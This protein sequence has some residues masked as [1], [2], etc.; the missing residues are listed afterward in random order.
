MAAMPEKR[1]QLEI[2]SCSPPG[3]VRRF[4]TVFYI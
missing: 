2:A 3:T 4:F 1:E